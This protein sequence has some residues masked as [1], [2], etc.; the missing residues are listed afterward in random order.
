MS[1]PQG[2]LADLITYLKT[3]P[4]VCRLMTPQQVSLNK[5]LGSVTIL[6]DKGES[7]MQM[8]LRSVD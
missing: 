1:L 5:S 7:M 8:E 4:V 3:C 2:C 6:C